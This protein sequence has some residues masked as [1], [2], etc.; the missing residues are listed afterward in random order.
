MVA[1]NKSRN[2]HIKTVEEGVEIEGFEHVEE[3]HNDQTVVNSDIISQMDSENKD[4][5]VIQAK[6]LAK[7][8]PQAVTHNLF[9]TSGN[10]NNIKEKQLAELDQYVVAENTYVP[11]QDSAGEYVRGDF[12]G[13]ALYDG[14]SLEKAQYI[15]QRLFNQYAKTNATFYE[16]NFQ[17]GKADFFLVKKSDLTPDDLAKATKMKPIS[18]ALDLNVIDEQNKAVMFFPRVTRPYRYDEHMERSKGKE[19]SPEE[20]AKWDNFSNLFNGVAVVGD[21][22]EIEALDKMITN[23]S[24]SL[25]GKNHVTTRKIL[26]PKSLADQALMSSQT[27]SP[28]LGLKKEYVRDAKG[29][30][31][32]EKGNVVQQD[33]AKLVTSLK[34]NLYAVNFLINRPQDYMNSVTYEKVFTVIEDTSNPGKFKEG[35]AFY[36][37]VTD[38]LVVEGIGASKMRGEL[39]YK[40]GNYFLSDFP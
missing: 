29:N 13:V 15:Q 31:L 28:V 25:T 38:S 2:S 32:D 18:R 22:K 30:F 19:T 36:M 3:V 24:G 1:K 34:N 20:K 7:H 33:K 14:N 10:L 17:Q 40:N 21:K 9:I 39:G 12:R 23:F 26:N 27:K 6:N 35:Q 11:S 8:S 5:P 4:R 37:K 16:S